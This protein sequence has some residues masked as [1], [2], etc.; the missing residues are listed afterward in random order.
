MHGQ[1]LPWITLA[2]PQLWHNL[3]DSFHGIT[4]NFMRL[5]AMMQKV[6]H[7]EWDGEGMHAAIF[8]TGR[9]AC[10]DFVEI[11][12]FAE[13]GTV[14]QLSNCFAD[15]MNVRWWAAIS[16][17]IPL[18]Q[19]DLKN[20]KSSIS[21]STEIALR[22]SMVPIG[23]TTTIPSSKTC[24]RRRRRSF[25]TNHVKLVAEA[26]KTVSRSTVSL[27]WPARS[28]YSIHNQFG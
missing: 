10:E 16:R 21:R 18:R 24:M 9:L 26:L 6:F 22:S 27:Q 4:D 14:L 11:A 19:S 2:S 5:A 15:F 20:I 1:Q 13:H 28:L 25:A 3:E 17:Q 8:S 12:F 23:S 7:R